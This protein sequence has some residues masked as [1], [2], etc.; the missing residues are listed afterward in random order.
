MTG[1]INLHTCVF[2]LL[3]LCFA[4]FRKSFVGFRSKSHLSPL[5][6]EYHQRP[7]DTIRHQ[8][9]SADT[10]RDHQRPT[11]T[12]RHQQTPPETPDTTRDW[13]TPPETSRHYQRPPETSRQKLRD[14]HK[15]KLMPLVSEKSKT[16]SAEIGKEDIFAN[17]PNLSFIYNFQAQS[18]HLCRKLFV[19]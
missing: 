1:S 2:L 4:R 3:D 18:F 16:R 5:N 9:R 6:L 17:L 19:G 11:E 12:S 14:Q 10:S 13:Q 8:Q 15:L 7:P